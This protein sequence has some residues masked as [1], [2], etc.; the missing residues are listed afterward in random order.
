MSWTCFSVEIGRV[1]SSTPRGPQIVLHDRNE[2]GGDHAHHPE[3]RLPDLEVA[4]EL[5]L[6]RESLLEG[7]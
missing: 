6:G 1:L 4:S 7:G 3:V 2:A 5:D